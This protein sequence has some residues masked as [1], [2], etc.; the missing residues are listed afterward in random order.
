VDGGFVEVHDNPK[1][2]KSDAAHALHTR[3]LRAVLTELG[4]A[5]GF[6]RRPRYFLA[7]CG[8]HCHWIAP[9]SCT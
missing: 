9:V 3:N 6:R 5:E 2:A 1:Q 7:A 4:R 8:Q